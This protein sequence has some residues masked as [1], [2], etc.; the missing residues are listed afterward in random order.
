MERQ[1]SSEAPLSRSAK[2]L[3]RERTE[4]LNALS[5]AMG[6]TLIDEAV[7]CS[8]RLLAVLDGPQPLSSR[9]VMIAY[10]GGKDSS[11]LTAFVRYMQLSIWQML[12][13]T[14]QLRAVT[15]RHAAMSQAVMDNIDRAYRA[16][17]MLRDPMVS[18]VVV[19][20]DS[21]WR[22]RRELPFPHAVARRNRE[23]I[24]MN[25]HKF[26]A[27]ARPTFCNACNISMLNAFGIGLA[28]DGG[29][30]V[31][32]TGDSK[33]ERR[34]YYKWVSS[35][36]RRLGL[37]KLDRQ[38]QFRGFLK[39]IDDVSHY[40]FGEVYAEQAGPDVDGRVFWNIP[41]DPAFFSIYEDT[42]YDVGSHWNVVVDLL[43]FRF[44]ELMFSFSESDCGNPSLMAHIRGLRAESLLAGSYHAGVREYADFG[45][46]LMAKKDFPERLI[47]QMRARLA[48][49]AQI[50]LFRKTITRFASDTY[51]LHDTQLACMIHS[52]FSDRGARLTRWLES[53]HPYLL[54]RDAE[55]RAML[56][57]AP[58]EPYLRNVLEDLSGLT[59]ENMQRLHR[60]SSVPNMGD[61]RAET[62]PLSAILKRDPH[63]RPIATSDANRAPTEYISGR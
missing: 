1:L 47:E 6:P 37:P 10:G 22:F 5:D 61:A 43:G 30:D 51:R 58:A 23:D 32:I 19:Q 27:D 49:E 60:S 62:I 53:C 18:A 4:W 54:P 13:E 38:E 14:F 39:A 7:R 8:A 11:Y 21:V 46:W 33:F 36:S 40:Y 59:L 12:G 20:G 34:A 31:V 9:V 56:G 24:L 35:L 15:N 63:K 48:N 41:K 17:G 52:P 50:D 57:G 26:H 25:G 2:L 55:I 16:L 42:S 29:A 44:D 3:H 28:V 45:Y